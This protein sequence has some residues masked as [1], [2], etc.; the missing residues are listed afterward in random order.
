MKGS[1][2]AV[3]PF[4]VSQSC[5]RQLDALLMNRAQKAERLIR[6]VGVWVFQMC[7]VDTDPHEAA[8]NCA[9]LRRGRPLVTLVQRLCTEDLSECE[10]KSISR[11]R[12]KNGG[13]HERFWI[14]CMRNFRVNG[15]CSL[16][17]ESPAVHIAGPIRTGYTILEDTVPQRIEP[18][19][20]L[21]LKF[22]TSA[23]FRL[24]QKKAGKS[25]KALPTLKQREAVGP[26]LTNT[27]VIRKNE[28]SSGNSQVS[29]TQRDVG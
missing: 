1:I 22:S 28:V 19:G 27:S 2:A 23:E 5:C 21:T 18:L 4:S 17:R 10:E 14:D 15:G 6:R 25:I 11:I 24:A 29:R 7:S 16:G 20:S 12:G 8:T 9:R 3:T 13:K 26:R